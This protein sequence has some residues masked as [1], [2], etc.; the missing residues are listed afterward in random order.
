MNRLVRNIIILV[1]ALALLGGG[2]WWL[3]NAEPDSGEEEQETVQ[4]TSETVYKVTE[5]DVT[6]IEIENGGEALTFKK[7][8]EEWIL[9]GYAVSEV[10]Q[11]KVKSLV[12]TVSS[13]TSKNK[14]EDSAETC[15]LD[16]PQL[17]VRV[18]LADG[19]V[20]TIKIGN[21]SAVL[22]EYFCS[23]NDGDIYTMYSYKVDDLMKKAEHYTEFSRAEITGSEIY[24]IKIERVGK[25]TLHVREKTEADG[26]M[27]AWEV[28]SPYKNT[29]N[30]IDQYIQEKMQTA[31][32]EISITTPAAKGANTGLSSPKA[33][34]TFLSAPVDE[35]G[36][37][38]EK[39]TTVIKV[40]NTAGDVTYIE[41]NGSAYEVS[42]DVMSFVNTDEFL[43]VSKLLALVPVQTLNTM[44]VS[45]NQTYTMEISHTNIGADDDEIGFKINGKAAD[46]DKA[47]KAYQ[48]VIGLAAD[49]VYKGEALGDVIAEVTF[50]SQNSEKVVTF[51]SINELSASFTIDGITEF[52]VKKTSVVA[53]LDAI[54]EFAENPLK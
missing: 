40:G 13:I 42:S 24:D 28:V 54:K 8:G 30:A 23:V 49:G 33:V 31:L 19:T 52:T 45:A 16:N 21:R 44:T 32:E 47:K 39:S 53:M 25:N 17:V 43:V 4:T 27:T 6:A 22:G 35:E 11:T 26:S 41:Y 37:R 10:S 48:E 7:S 14:V 2:F 12:S 1:A 46:E 9:D 34:I 36:N 29:Y 50:S 18:T 38:G 3:M 15:G 5:N 20:D 51:R